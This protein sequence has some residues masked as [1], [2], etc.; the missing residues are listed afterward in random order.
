MSAPPLSPH[1][2]LTPFTSRANALLR[3]PPTTAAA[4]ASC[5]SK[6][7]CTLYLTIHTKFEL[8][9]FIK[10]SGDYDALDPGADSHSHE[11]VASIHISH[12]RDN[13]QS[14][15]WLHLICSCCL[16]FYVTTTDWAFLLLFSGLQ[17]LVDALKV[18]WWLL[19]PQFLQTTALSSLENFKTGEHSSNG[20]LQILQTSSLSSPVAIIFT[21]HIYIL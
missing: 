3:H 9:P 8:S 1:H 15:S 6:D 11:K 13:N 19:V 21:S 5:K 14:L 2:Q 16:Q 7:P 4:V 12:M 17:R 10:A 20:A 18:E